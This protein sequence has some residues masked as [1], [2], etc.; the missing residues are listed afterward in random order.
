MMPDKSIP[1]PARIL[2]CVGPSPAGADLI[3]AAQKMAA[4]AK[5]AWFAVYVE[6]PKM[7]RLPDTKLQSNDNL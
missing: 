5:A 7:L 3:K 2:V 1:T 4:G 6:N